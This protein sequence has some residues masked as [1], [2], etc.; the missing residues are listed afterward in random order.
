M[1]VNSCPALLRKINRF[2]ID[3]NQTYKLSH[4]VPQEGRFANRHERWARDAVDAA[5]SRAKRDRRAGS[6]VSDRQTRKTNGA[7]AYGEIV[8]SW[9]PL[10]MSS[11]AEAS[12]AQPGY[13]AIQS[14]RRRWQ[15]EFVTGEITYKP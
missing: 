3:P 6:P 5:A 11:R 13:E 9:H 2:A 7:E 4:P 15:K 12:S 14:A 10:L 1:L 8:W